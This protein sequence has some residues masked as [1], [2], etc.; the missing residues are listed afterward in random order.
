LGLADLADAACGGPEGQNCDRRRLNWAG[1]DPF[2]LG[3]AN[4]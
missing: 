3:A 2:P 4:D 1:F